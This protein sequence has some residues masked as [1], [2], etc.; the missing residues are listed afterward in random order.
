MTEATEDPTTAT[1]RMRAYLAAVPVGRD[2]GWPR[3]DVEQLLAERDAL[4]AT[5]AEVAQAR[6]NGSVTMEAL[7]W[8]IVEKRRAMAERDACLAETNRAR[9]AEQAA[10]A[11]AAE[12]ENVI[13]WDVTC[14]GCARLLDSCVAETTR[15]EK[16][17]AL[18]RRVRDVTAPEPASGWQ[19]TYYDGWGDALAAVG[20][21]LDVRDWEE[22]DACQVVEADGGPVR[23]HGQGD[24]TPEG[25]EALGAV[26]AA[27]KRAMALEPPGP[28]E[29]HCPRCAAVPGRLCRR[30]NGPGGRAPHDERRALA[31]AATTTPK[32]TTP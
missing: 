16:A 30:E 29:F 12:L 25:V 19:A 10:L 1:D 22:Q 23:I 9:D 27:A 32:E 6:A 15:A 13:T 31:A 7:A 4:A 17:E 21:A 8:R 14:G 11:R 18:I 26:V 3:A 24:L 5:V 20:D 2:E 28:N